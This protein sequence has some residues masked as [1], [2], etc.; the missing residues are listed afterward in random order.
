MRRPA[1]HRPSALSTRPLLTASAGARPSR[2]EPPENPGR[3]GR[4][5]RPDE[6]GRSPRSRG[7]RSLLP[8][9]ARWRRRL[10]SCALVREGDAIRLTARPPRSRL[11][12]LHV[13]RSRGA[14]RA[15]SAT[16]SSSVI[17]SRRFAHAGRELSARSP[18]PARAVFE[19]PTSSVTCT[20]SSSSRGDNTCSIV[21]RDCMCRRARRSPPRPATPRSRHAHAA[22]AVVLRA[23]LRLDAHQSRMSATT[24]SA[25]SLVSSTITGLLVDPSRGARGRRHSLSG[26]FAHHRN[27]TLRAVPPTRLGARPPPPALPRAEASR[28]SSSH[29]AARGHHVV[30]GPV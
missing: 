12:G 11:V 22:A 13:R 19:T 16:A 15:F 30:H 5:G 7:P 17:S 27:L 26:R 6:R 24:C 28:A 1:A 21:C 10:Q 14:R 2:L 8:L 9:V 3:L 23:H 4:S 29:T 25:R 18:A 20:R